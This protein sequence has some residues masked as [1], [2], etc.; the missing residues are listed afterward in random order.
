MSSRNVWVRTSSIALALGLLTLAV[1]AFKTIQHD[2]I[3]GELETEV[4]FWGRG[5]YQPTQATRG[6]IASLLERQLQSNPQNSHLLALR[7][8]Q[9][10]WE[11]FWSDSDE[12]YKQYSRRA[13][14]A[15]YVALLTRP[16]YGQGWLK[17]LQYQAVDESGEEL[18]QEARARLQKLKRW[19]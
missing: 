2:L 10:A 15:Q 4:S 6:S 16:A 13:I 7:A 19:Q 8:N 5:A 17:L 3:F 18:H 1:H 12:D 14:E 11:G 9:L